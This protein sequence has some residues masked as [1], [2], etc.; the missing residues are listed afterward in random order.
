MTSNLRY[1]RW[2]ALRQLP[3][4]AVVATLVAAATL[5]VAQLMPPQFAPTARLLMSAT[6]VS[7]G[8]PTTGSDMAAATHLQNIE[9][10]LL[11]QTRLEKLGS[12]VDPQLTADML[13]DAITTEII[14][15]RGKATVMA[16]SVSSPDADLATKA[17]NQLAAKVLAEHRA[18]RTERAEDALAFF[19]QEVAS[20]RQQLDEKYNALHGFMADH[21]GALPH[22]TLG[23][24]DQ[25]R[26]LLIRLGAKPEPSRRSAARM[27]LEAELEEARAIFSDQ[28][29]TVLSLL[30]KIQELEPNT[31]EITENLSVVALSRI[32]ALLAQIPMNELALNALRRDHDRAQAQY[33]AAIQ[34]LE[35]ARIEQRIA[36]R[37]EGDQLTIVEPAIRPDLP[38]GPRQKI[39]F[40]A[41]SALA[42]VLAG[43]A[44]ILMARSDTKLRRPIDLHTSLG[45]TPYAVIPQMQP[46]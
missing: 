45:L 11:T 46:T 19:R 13:R 14:S 38:E 9:T 42:I 33:D 22:D 21:A 20:S 3:V 26:D 18:I 34:R 44:A 40:A 41:G 28:H 31:P 17:T 6:S 24:L 2:L 39:I 36:M 29:P 1:Y 10:R 16:V 12:L 7:Q 8:M 30:A 43:L 35:T 25:R 27:Q 23:Y 4:F 5:V 37:T 15:G 32:D